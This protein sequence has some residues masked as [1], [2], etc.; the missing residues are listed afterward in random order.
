MS[1]QYTGNHSDDNKR[2]FVADAD[3][4][5]ARNVT[6]GAGALGSLLQGVKYDFIGAT[7]PTTSQEV[8]TYRLGGSGGAVSAVIEVTYTD[9]TKANL[10][11]AERTA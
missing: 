3:G 9:S 11:S 6:L 10:L 8:Y 4:N 1:N 7:Y 5:A 2:S